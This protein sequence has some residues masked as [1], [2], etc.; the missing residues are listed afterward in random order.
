MVMYAKIRRMFYREHLSINEIQ[1]RHESVA[2]HDKKV[3]ESARR[4]HGEISK[5]EEAWQADTI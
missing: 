4:Q 3:I 5:S 1:R 2:E